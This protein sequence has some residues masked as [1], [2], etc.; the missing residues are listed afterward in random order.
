MVAGGHKLDYPLPALS[1]NAD[2]PS[3]ESRE[4]AVPLLM[5]A[6]LRQIADNRE[7]GFVPRR[8]AIPL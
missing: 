2:R 6:K 8:S 4:A 3:Q 5:G 7:E 1:I